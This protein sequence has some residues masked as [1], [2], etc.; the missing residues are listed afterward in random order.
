MD[1]MPCLITVTGKLVADPSFRLPGGSFFDAFEGF[2]LGEVPM[3]MNIACPN[4]DRR[5]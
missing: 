2:G 1:L 5:V 4:L 3:I